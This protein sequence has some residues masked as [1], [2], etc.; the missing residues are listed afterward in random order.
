MNLFHALGGGQ[1]IEET[2]SVNAW[3]LYD[4][5]SDPFAEVVGVF[6]LFLFQM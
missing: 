6:T 5:Y 1:I 3:Q 4:W 2:Y